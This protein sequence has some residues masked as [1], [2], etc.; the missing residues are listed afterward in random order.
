MKNMLLT[1]TEITESQCNHK[2]IL[3]NAIIPTV[4]G[5]MINNGM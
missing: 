3:R 1:S 4:E 5:K 2:L